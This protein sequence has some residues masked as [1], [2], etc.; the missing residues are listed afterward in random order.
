MVSTE[1][2]ADVGAIG[3]ALEPLAP[4]CAESSEGDTRG[5]EFIS[6]NV[7]LSLILATKIMTQTRDDFE[8][9]GEGHKARRC[10]K[11][12]YPESFIIKYATPTEIV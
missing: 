4:T 6:G 11:V 3:L 12:A 10:R 9:C 5:C 8:C 7:F 2:S 1:D